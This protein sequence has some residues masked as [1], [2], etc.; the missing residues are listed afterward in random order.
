MLSISFHS[1]QY[2]ANCNEIS[3]TMDE[4]DLAAS[5]DD[6]GQDEE[7]VEELSKKHMVSINCIQSIG[8]L[9]VVFDRDLSRACLHSAPTLLSNY[10]S[11]A[12]MF[13]AVCIFVI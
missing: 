3:T 7:S 10:N 13:E 1:F 11:V 4:L 6:L 12:R 9:F 2:F 5:N 8:N